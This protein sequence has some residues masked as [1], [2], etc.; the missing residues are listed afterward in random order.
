MPVVVPVVVRRGIRSESSPNPLG[1]NAGCEDLDRSSGCAG[2]LTLMVAFLSKD[3][4]SDEGIGERSVKLAKMGC[5]V[6][7]EARTQSALLPL[8]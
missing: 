5:E 3:D 6:S 2:G 1:R 8:A 7:V 4:Y